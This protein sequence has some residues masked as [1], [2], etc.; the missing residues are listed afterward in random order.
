MVSQHTEVLNPGVAALIGFA[1][2]AK[3]DRFVTHTLPFG[4]N[5]DDA[6]GTQGIGV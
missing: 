2:Q 4:F 3:L 6:T 5:P 1:T